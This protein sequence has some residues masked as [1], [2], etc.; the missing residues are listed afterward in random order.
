M[1]N[2]AFNTLRLLNGGL[3]HKKLKPYLSRD[4]KDGS[5]YL[6][7]DKIIPMPPSLGIT[8]GSGVDEAI[9]VLQGKAP[10]RSFT[11]KDLKEARQGIQNL[12]KYGHKNWYDW[13]CDKWGTKWNSYDTDW[14]G[15][16]AHAES[17]RFC[18]AWCPPTPVIEKLAE[19]IGEPLELEWWAEG[20]ESEEPATEVFIPQADEK[21]LRV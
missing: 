15:D 9:A 12:K 13:R 7:F 6:D 20:G 18:T 10:A 14:D 21:G 3:I 5:T 11:K 19:L 17:I 8:A 1:P 16:F 4:R 2:H